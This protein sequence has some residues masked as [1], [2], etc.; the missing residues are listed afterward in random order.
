MTKQ[1]AIKLFEESHLIKDESDMQRDIHDIDRILTYPVDVAKVY[2]KI[3]Y[4]NRKHPEN[5]VLFKLIYPPVGN[6]VP[7]SSA[8]KDNLI[9]DLNWKRTFLNAKMRAKS[10]DEFRK[11][12]AGE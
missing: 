9:N 10:F 7:L 6:P 2:D 3:E 4:I 12:M 5:I 1:E 11:E 8:T